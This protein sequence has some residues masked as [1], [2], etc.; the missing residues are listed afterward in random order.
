MDSDNNKSLSA[1]EFSSV[2]TAIT[3]AFGDKTRR[4]IYLF[5]H[6]NSVG[7]TAT[8]TAREFDLHPNVA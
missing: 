7:I 1:T 5:A 6:E 4:D 3:V 8:Q 2:V